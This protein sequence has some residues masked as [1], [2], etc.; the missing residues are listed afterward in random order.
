VHT[1]TNTV[2]TPTNS[3]H[4]P[5]NT[6]HTPTNNVHTSSL[7]P[8]TFDS[9]GS[10]ELLHLCQSSQVEG[11][12]W[13]AWRLT[14]TETR[15]LMYETSYVLLWELPTCDLCLLSELACLLPFCYWHSVL[16]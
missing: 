11:G 5:T 12:M 13:L 15:H 9:R 14:V 3:V 1:P 6:V 16:L 8:H 10:V 2:H 4:T 7:L